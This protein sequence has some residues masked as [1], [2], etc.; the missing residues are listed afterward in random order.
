[1]GFPGNCNMWFAVTDYLVW[2]LNAEVF[3][4]PTYSQ[5]EKILGHK[6]LGIYM[7]IESSIQ[8]SES[9]TKTL[10]HLGAQLFQIVYF[11]ILRCG[12]LAMLVRH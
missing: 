8:N 6:A 1:M 5:V 7:K 12:H 3:L 4:I 11:F 2:E 9:R 10:K